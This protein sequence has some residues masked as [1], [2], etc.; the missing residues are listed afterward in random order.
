MEL[1][2][3]D[4]WT[5]QYDRRATEQAYALAKQGAHMCS[6]AYCRNYVAVRDAAYGATVS[7]LLV[8][9]G[10][11]PHKESEVSE[12]GE[13]ESGR[14][15][16]I[17]FYHFTGRI[18]RDPGD[19]MTHVPGSDSLG[20]TWQIFFTSGRSLVPESFGNSPVVQL[21]FQVELPWVLN[22]LPT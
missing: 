11:D 1:L 20:L 14:H 17:G 22:D 16:Y 10:I 2:K 7:A 13:G 8:Q 4:G 5:I 21:E 19:R 3:L 12:A 18:G 9:L 6:C 15:L